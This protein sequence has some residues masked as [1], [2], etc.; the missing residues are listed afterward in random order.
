MRILLLVDDPV[1]VRALPELLRL[2]M[3]G[4]TV[5]TGDAA[6]ALDRIAATD[7]DAILS[8]LELPGGVDGLALLGRIRALRP[9]TPTL[10]VVAEGEHDLAVQALRGGAYDVI[11]KPIDQDDFVASVR[12][13]VQTRQLLREVERLAFLAE[14]SMRLAASLDYPATLASLA[15]L[16]VPAL[17]DWCAVDVVEE[18]RSIRELA[19][20]HV[21]PSEAG[22]ARRARFRFPSDPAASHGVPKV[23]RTGQSELVPEV[24]DPLLAAAASSYMCVPLVARGRTLGALTLVAAESRRR[25]GPADLARAE[26]LARRAAL[27]ADNARLYQ[28]SREAVRA[29]DDFL[30]RASHEL[31]TPLTAALGTIRLLRRALADEV[32]ESL[33]SFIEV[34]NR[35]LGAMAALVNNLLDA[36]KLASGRETLTLEPVD[37]A[38]VVRTSL[39]VVGTQARDKGVALRAAVPTG[40]RVPADALKLEQVLVNLLA[41]AVKFTPAG[42]E[43]AV[44]A[45]GEGDG[46]L[47]RV[48]DTGEGIVR[49]HLQAIFEPFFQVG[50]RAAR[51]PRGTGLG[52]AICRQIVELH[53][54]AIWAESEGPGRGSTFT[55]RLPASSVGRATYSAA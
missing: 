28:A 5:D 7:Y 11:Q 31:R 10:V 51:R 33:G 9:D 52:L 16:A 37:L 8:D 14:V 1:L 47:M 12:R 27:A 50:R 42:G 35:N 17:A 25:Y 22:P 36:A 45:G 41:N 43:V 30:A 55:V 18:D 44:E 34:A 6:T 4:V 15:H 29:R 54:G 39:E 21:D 26:D 38:A 53:G 48:R 20:V 32:K 3:S 46:V 49:E 24:S 2:R 13:A 40:L 19:V 23:V